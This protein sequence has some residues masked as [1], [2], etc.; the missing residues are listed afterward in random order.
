[1]LEVGHGEVPEAMVIAA[2]CERFGWTYEE[3]HGQPSWFLEMIKL[4]LRL[5]A[6]H[7]MRESDKANNREH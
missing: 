7:E 1:M 6:E 5:D 4:K 3:Y 2:I